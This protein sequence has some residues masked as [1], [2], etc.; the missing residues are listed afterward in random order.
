MNSNT[1]TYLLLSYS[2]SQEQTAIVPP[3]CLPHFSQGLGGQGRYLQASQLQTALAVTSFV[4]SP[5]DIYQFLLTNN[6]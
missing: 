2:F 3:I 6:P 1:R 4:S 5:L